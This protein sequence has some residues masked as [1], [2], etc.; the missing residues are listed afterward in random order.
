LI[1]GGVGPPHSRVYVAL[2]GDSADD[3]DP[4]V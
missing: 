2:A 1:K 3:L 4:L